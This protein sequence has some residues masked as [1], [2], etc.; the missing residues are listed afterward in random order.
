VEAVT[1]FD[2]LSAANPNWRTSGRYDALFVQAYEMALAPP[3]FPRKIFRFD[4]MVVVLRPTKLQ[5]IE[6]AGVRLRFGES[7]QME[8]SADQ[9]VSVSDATPKLITIQPH[10]TQNLHE[11]RHL[12]D[13]SAEYISLLVCNSHRNIAFR[14]LFT[15]I[16]SLDGSSAGVQG[17]IYRLP[18]DVPRPDLSHD[19][20]DRFRRCQ[21]EIGALALEV[22]Q[23]VRLSLHWH[24][25][26]VQSDGLD[27]FL[28]LWIALETLSMQSANIADVNDQL[29]N[30][31]GISRSEAAA[32][33]GVGR[34]CGL[35]SRVVHNGERKNIS[36]DLTDYMECLY[37]DLLLFQVLGERLGRTRAFLRSKGL[38]VVELTKPAA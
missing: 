8:M 18:F 36:T 21:A 17:E 6:L 22:Q 29:G 23:K 5:F 1:T 3:A 4:D 26:G 31:Y 7:R 30:L 24:I 25:K 38:D 35:R 20:L 9:R 28:S 14:R 15:Q 11:D 10:N 16:V 13:R 19:A 2:P 12:E 27:S 37:A 32:E 33:F 34:I